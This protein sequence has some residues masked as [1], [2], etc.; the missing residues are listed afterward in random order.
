V[1]KAEERKTWREEMKRLLI[2]ILVAFILLTNIN[3]QGSK[4]GIKANEASNNN[5]YKKNVVWQYQ[6]PYSKD[7]KVMTEDELKILPYG[8]QITNNKIYIVYKYG[9]Y[10]IE[11]ADK[12]QKTKILLSELNYGDKVNKQ[13]EMENSK[14]VNLKRINKNEYVL[15]KEVREKLVFPKKIDPEIIGG[16]IIFIDEADNIYIQYQ[17]KDKTKKFTWLRG[18]EIEAN[19]YWIAKY[20]RNM[21]LVGVIKLEEALTIPEVVINEEGD[22]Y[23]FWYDVD[24][25]YVTMWSTK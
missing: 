22:I 14:R 15:K 1:D 6:Y 17:A 4:E 25:Y 7:K 10:A 12:T 19:T 2:I 23:Q 9:E 5:V 3:A 18:E 11:M 8:I 16:D 21:E 13:E 24:N 20:N